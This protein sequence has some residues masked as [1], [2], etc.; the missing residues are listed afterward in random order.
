MSLL[1]LALLVLACARSPVETPVPLREEP[2]S[3]TIPDTYYVRFYVDGTWY[4]AV[5]V[6][7]EDFLKSA[8]GPYLLEGPTYVRQQGQDL[9]ECYPLGYQVPQGAEVMVSGSRAP[10]TLKTMA[11]V[12]R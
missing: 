9:W 1:L 5:P 3:V 11:Q 2:R 7:S 12:C 8:A 4:H 6:S 10:V